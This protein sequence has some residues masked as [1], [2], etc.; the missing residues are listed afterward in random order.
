MCRA[1]VLASGWSAGR[2]LWARAA[3][4]RVLLAQGRT[5]EAAELD[6]RPQD[7]PS[8]LPDPRDGS[9]EALDE[10]VVAS[11]HATAVRTLLAAGSV[12]DAG[13]RARWLAGIAK[14]SKNPVAH[15]VTENCTF[16][17]TGR[18]R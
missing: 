18:H 15:V 16:A 10:V 4:A 8:E 14:E 5:D 9:D 11:I 6:L 12:F 17:G 13:Q 3:L 7:P 1:C 2:Q